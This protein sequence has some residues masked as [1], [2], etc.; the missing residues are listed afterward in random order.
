MSDSADYI[1]ERSTSYIVWIITVK[2]ISSSSISQKYL[3][4]FLINVFYKK[5]LQLMVSLEMFLET[6]LIHRTQQVM[7]DGVSQLLSSN[8]WSTPGYNFRAYYVPSLH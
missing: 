3:I 8:I 2:L 5:T 4:E 1:G 6:W 7:L